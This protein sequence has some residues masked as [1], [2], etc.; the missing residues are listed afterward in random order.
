MRI[1]V[2]DASSKKIL[3]KLKAANIGRMLCRIPR[4]LYEGEEWCFDNGAFADYLAGKSFDEDAFMRR[5]EK[6]I[7][8]MPTI[9]YLAV[10]P[11][12]VAGGDA[13]WDFSMKWLNSGKLPKE[14]PW[15]LAVQ[16]NMSTDW[17]ISVLDRPDLAGVFLGGSTQYKSWALY[18]RKVT[19]HFK[20]PFHYARAGTV[21]KLAHAVMCGADSIDSTTPLWTYA[22]LDSFLQALTQPCF[23]CPDDFLLLR[24]LPH[25]GEGAYGGV[26]R[27]KVKDAPA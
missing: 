7:A 9:P 10:L 6:F 25:L 27:E 18:W 24:K 8:R 22:R 23:F 20:K 11:D 4:T 13:S 17:V 14:W 19:A 15:Y 1:F 2:G 16:D 3:T 21:D 5:L 12:I 26:T